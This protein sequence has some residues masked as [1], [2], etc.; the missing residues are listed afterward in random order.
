MSEVRATPA[1][2]NTEE[3]V[4]VLLNGDFTDPGICI[5]IELKFNVVLTI[6]HFV[7]PTV[8]KPVKARS[9]SQKSLL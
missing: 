8:S 6:N 7:L 5:F 9:R 2:G 1:P 3:T 4:V